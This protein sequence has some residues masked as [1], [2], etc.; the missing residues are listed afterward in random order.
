VVIIHGVESQTGN[1]NTYK[2]RFEDHQGDLVE[3]VLSSGIDTVYETV[4]ATEMRYSSG[5]NRSF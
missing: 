2:S 4:E 1:F 3:I 5:Y